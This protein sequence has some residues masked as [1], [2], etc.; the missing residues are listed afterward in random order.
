MSRVRQC[1]P[2]SYSKRKFYPIFCY[3][4]RQLANTRSPQWDKKRLK[5]QIPSSLQRMAGIH[6]ITLIASYPAKSRCQ[7]TLHLLPVKSRKPKRRFVPAIYMPRRK[8][9]KVIE[10]TLKAEAHCVLFRNVF[11]VSR[12]FWYITARIQI[13]PACH[14][15]E[16]SSNIEQSS[17]RTQLAGQPF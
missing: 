11:H 12:E 1:T 9:L 8:P 3:L 2:K 5:W 14:L 17:A 15:K 16:H 6:R 13:N 7:D 10:F 4:P